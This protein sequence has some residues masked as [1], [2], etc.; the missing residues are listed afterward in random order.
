MRRMRLPVHGQNKTN[1]EYCKAHGHPLPR[2]FDVLDNSGGPGAA[3]RYKVW[4]SL[5]SER[6]ELPTTYTAVC[7]GEE[8][9]ARKV[10]GHLRSREM[11][12][13]A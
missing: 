12:E 4:V 6:L 7:E 5:G 9:L 3:V 11:G 1:I 10:L 8:K 13:E 2:F